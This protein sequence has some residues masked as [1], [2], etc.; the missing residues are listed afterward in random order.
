MDGT[1][2]N[3]RYDRIGRTA[4][5]FDLGR[6]VDEVPIG[7]NL[8]LNFNDIRVRSFILPWRASNV[9]TMR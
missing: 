6:R 4:D 2:D 1:R 5:K 3:G 7:R 8:Y 9:L